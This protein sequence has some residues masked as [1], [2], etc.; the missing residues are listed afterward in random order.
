M[1]WEAYREGYEDARYL[2]TLQHTIVCAQAAGSGADVL[3]AEINGWLAGLATDVNL[4]IWRLTMADYIEQLH[5]IRVDINGDGFFDL[6]D[7][8]HIS[9]QWMGAPLVPSAD[10]SPVCGD[11][12]V[13]NGDL[14][15]FLN[16]WL[17]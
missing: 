7:F 2:A 12:I 10:I 8:L 16:H 14:E 11:G 17:D 13:N 9:N 3:I 4:D 5:L 1:P 15:A 6:L